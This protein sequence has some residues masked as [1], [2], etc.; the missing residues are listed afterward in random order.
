MA[1]EVRT[2][3]A[4]PIDWAMTQNNLG[5]A[6]L[7]RI[8]DQKAQNLED[9]IACYQ[10]ALSVFTREAFPIDWAMTQN[11]LGNAYSERITDQ[12]AQNLEEAFA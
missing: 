10:L 12:K 6:Y 7:E 4:F 2:R 3:E 1:L 11:N 9:A 8:T 5:N